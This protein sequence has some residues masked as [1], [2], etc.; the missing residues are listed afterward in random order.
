M[1]TG[2][3]IA[4]LVIFGMVAG[5]FPGWSPGD[6]MAL[7]GLGVLMA[8][9][10]WRYASIRVDVSDTGLVVRNLILTTSLRWDEIVDFEFHEGDAWPHLVLADHDTLAVMAIQRS[11]GA[12]GRENS[13]RLAELLAPHITVADPDNDP[14]A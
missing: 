10:M 2:V 9:L 6:R 12:V 13:V 5:F 8:G 3:A 11:D 4:A 1:A 7:F 14:D